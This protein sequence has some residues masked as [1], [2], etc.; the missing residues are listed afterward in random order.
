MMLIPLPNFLVISLNRTNLCL[1]LIL[2]WCR[3]GFLLW[4]FTWRIRA[5]GGTLSTWYY[6]HGYVRYKLR[7]YLSCFVVEFVRF[8]DFYCIT[9]SCSFLNAMINNWKFAHPDLLLHIIE[10]I[11][12]SSFEKFQLLH[13]AKLNFF[14]QEE[15]FFWFIYPVSMS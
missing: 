3:Y 14:I 10:L 8:Y 13:P 12:W 5:M 1:V 9:L 2:L 4:L 15:K 6:S 7:D 11:Y